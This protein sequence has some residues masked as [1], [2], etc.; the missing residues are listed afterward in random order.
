M[1]GEQNN[2]GQSNYRIP[3]L[4]KII[5]LAMFIG[6]IAAVAISLIILFRLSGQN[7]GILSGLGT[8]FAAISCIAGLFSMV[9]AL[10]I[11]KLRFWSLCLISLPAIFD[12]I[13]Y[14]FLFFI[15]IFTT[16]ILRI[17]PTFFANIGISLLVPTYLWLSYMFV[18]KGLNNSLNL[19]RKILGV[20]IAAFFIVALAIFLYIGIMFG[21]ALKNVSNTNNG[22]PASYSTNTAGMKANDTKRKSDL[23][24]I[25]NAVELYYEDH[26]NYPI[27]SD[28]KKL[29]ETLEQGHYINKNYEDPLYPKQNYRYGVSEDGQYYR[30]DTQ[31]EV[32]NDIS[33]KNDNGVDPNKYEIG[34]ALGNNADKVTCMDTCDE[35][36]PTAKGQVEDVVGKVGLL[37][38][39]PSDETPSLATVTDAEALKKEN[40]FYKEAQNGDKILIYVKSAKAILYRP[41]INKIISVDNNIILNK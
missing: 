30:L 35:S 3:I 20:I 1:I 27:A 5:A 19:F 16:G 24:S 2:T 12:V 36:Q 10:G 22:Q 14:I 4:V 34:P 6:G 13:Y 15:A 7:Y 9:L 29:I 33:S 38:T 28:F 37:M 26:G 18:F 41:S 39:L 17:L 8:I 31:L 32:N 11:K 40:Q 23:R 21:F 25:G